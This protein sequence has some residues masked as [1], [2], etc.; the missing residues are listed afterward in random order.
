[1]VDLLEHFVCRAF[2]AVCILRDQIPHLLRVAGHDRDRVLPGI[3]RREDHFSAIGQAAQAAD[4]PKALG[5]ADQLVG[6]GD[7]RKLFSKLLP[8]DARGIVLDG[9]GPPLAVDVDLDPSLTFVRKQTQLTGSI[10]LVTGILDVFPVDYPRVLVHSGGQVFQDI[11][12]KD[13]LRHGVHFL[14]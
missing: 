1:M 7:I 13:I 2:V 10:D 5:L 6:I 11:R 12:A 4:P 8:R 3:F 9:D 14:T